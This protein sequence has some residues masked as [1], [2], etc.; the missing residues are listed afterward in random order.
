MADIKPL[1]QIADKWKRVT[2]QRTQDYEQGVQ[3]PRRDWAQSTANASDRYKEGIQSAINRG[4][5]AKG[6]TNAGSGKW[7]EKTLAKGPNR[8]AEGVAQSGGDY[9]DGFAPYHQVISSTTLPPRFPTGD[10]RNIQRVSVLNKAL[11]KKKESGT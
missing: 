1:G 4:A 7:Q 9:E 8:F 2:P 3:Q 5:F 10:D 11:R 6:V